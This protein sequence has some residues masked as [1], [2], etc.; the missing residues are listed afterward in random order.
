MKIYLEDQGYTADGFRLTYDRL[1]A[2]DT[3]SIAM[4]DTRG[5]RHFVVV[6]GVEAERILI[7]DPALGLQTYSRAEFEEAW[8]GVAFLI[9]PPATTQRFNDRQEW[10]TY[11]PAPW[12]TAMATVNL[13]QWRE[14]PALYQI[15]PILNLDSI[16]Q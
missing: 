2:L 11:A 16:L 15:A 12:A 13:D 4:V 7:G 6:K 8:N 10:L 9:R 1:L 14:V 3:P 5:Y